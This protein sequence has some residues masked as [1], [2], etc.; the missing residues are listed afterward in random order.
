M[1]CTLV[2][3]IEVRRVVCCRSSPGVIILRELRNLRGRVEGGGIICCALERM[4]THVS[5]CAMMTVRMNCI[6]DLE[7]LPLSWETIAIE[8]CKSYRR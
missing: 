3:V 4:V 8:S 7:A 6:L 2:M 5:T 1:I